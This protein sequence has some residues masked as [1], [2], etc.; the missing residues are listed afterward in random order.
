MFTYINKQGVKSNKGF[1]VQFTGRFTAEYREGTKTITIELEN[2]IL[3]D[4]KYCEI[5]K[6]DAF[7]EWDDG[8]LIPSEKQ[9]EIL[10]N[11]TEAVEFQGLGVV[12]SN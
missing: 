3:P 10:K 4:G 9:Q 5:I 2:G 11:F 8:V 7:I 12:V 1:V 6:P